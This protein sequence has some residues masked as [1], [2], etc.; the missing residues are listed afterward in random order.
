MRFFPWFVLLLLVFPLLELYLLI[1]VG[2]LIGAFPTI[3]LVVGTAAAGLWLARRQGLQ[4][5]RR[6][7][8]AL[9]RGEMP[10]VEMMEGAVMFIGGILLLLPGLITDFL[11]FLCLLPPVRR[12]VVAWWLRRAQVRVYRTRPAAGGNVY[13][14][15]YRNLPHGGRDEDER[16]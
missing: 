16:H 6:I 3:V 5:Y 7:Q 1:K 9:A 11:G 10:A 2:T 13:E 4:N 14:A 15:D 12:A 8:A